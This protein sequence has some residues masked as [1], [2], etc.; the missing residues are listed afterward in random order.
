[1]RLEVTV[2]NLLVPL[3]AGA[4]VTSLPQN[5]LAN[6]MLKTLPWLVEG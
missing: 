4:V 6:E 2:L 3:N 5:T 1:M